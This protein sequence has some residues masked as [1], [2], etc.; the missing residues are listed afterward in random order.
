[1]TSDVNDFSIVALGG[2]HGLAN[3]LRAAKRITRDVTGIVV[4]SDDGGSSGRLRRDFGMIP[5]GDLRRAVA[6][7]CPEDSEG[8]LWAE[9]L[10]H[11][12]AAGDVAGH[13][14]GNLLIA[15]LWEETDEIIDGLQ[16]LASLLRISGRVLPVALEPIQMAA[17]VREGAAVR[18]VAGQVEIA[19][20][21]GHVEGISIEPADVAGCPA[22]VDAILRADLVVLGPGSWYTSVLTHL[23]VGDIRKALRETRA[24][25][26]VVL[27]LA[28][29]PGETTHFTPET[30][31][32]VLA[33]V[34]PDVRFDAVVADLAHVADPVMLAAASGRLGA[35]VHAGAVATADGG[36]THDPVR[37]AAVLEVLAKDGRIAAWQ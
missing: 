33:D 6:A 13:V 23:L 32:E 34:A 10:Q 28:P 17:K 8:R 37:L 35:R 20:T 25:K 22:A 4:V 24:M 1:M 11:R 36:H 30:H 15:A 3:T 12:F 16:R 31:L 21:N 19:T 5:P 2:G 26:V 18:D 27:N 29:Q 14:L 9:V 7:L